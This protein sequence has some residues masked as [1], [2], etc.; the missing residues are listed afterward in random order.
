MRQIKMDFPSFFNC[1]N[2]LQQDWDG[3]LLFVCLY[4]CIVTRGFVTL[5]QSRLSHSVTT[6]SHLDQLTQQYTNIC[7]CTHTCHCCAGGN[8]LKRPKDEEKITSPV[9]STAMTS[10]KS[11]VLNFHTHTRPPPRFSGKN[12][13]TVIF[14]HFNSFSDEA[15]K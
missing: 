7:N 9:F 8:F 13:Y 6:T 15:Q 10:T 14:P 5:D 12:F 4:E 1:T 3:L 2:A 11:P